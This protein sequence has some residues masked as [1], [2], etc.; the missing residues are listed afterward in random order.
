MAS[1]LRVSSDLFLPIYHKTQFHRAVIDEIQNPDLKHSYQYC[2]EVTRRYA[3]TFYFAARFLPTHKQRGIFAVYALCRYIDNVV[4]EAEDLISN[5]KLTVQEVLEK[6]DELELLLESVYSGSTIDNPVL[7]AFSDTLNHFY[8]PIKWPKLLIEGVKMDLAKDRYLNFEEIYNYSYKVA[9]VVG[10]MSSEI[11]GYTHKDAL[12]NAEYLGIAMQLT[13]ILRDVGE[14]ARR[15]RIYLPQ[16]ELA[17]FEVSEHEIIAEK[18]SRNFIELMK[19]Q[20]K[21]ARNYYEKAY[22]G[23]RLLHRDSRLPVYLAH[24]NYSRILD[25]IEDMDYNV[26]EKRA[27]LTTSEKLKILPKAL[28][29]IQRTI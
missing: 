5:E 6:L 20:V 22:S 18:Y 24:L 1:I 10:M 15:G 11:F 28:Y 23:I 17:V 9:S 8:I 13:N 19:F 7:T 4:D 12:E 27:F 29:K 16:T 3:K 14:D 26:F 21:R 25:K 2:R